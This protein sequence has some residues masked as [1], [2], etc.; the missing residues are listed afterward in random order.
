[1]SAYDGAPGRAAVIF[2]CGRNA[3]RSPMAEAL[4]R[5]RFGGARPAVSCGVEPAAW[6]DGFMIAV[7]AEDGVDMEAFECRGLEAVKGLAPALVV[8]MA[9]EADAPAKRLAQTSGARFEA[10]PLSDPALERGGRESKL[11]AYRAVR[12]EIA[13]RIARCA[14]ESG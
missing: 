1:M 4:W 9:P 13:A 8:S 7:M 12:D 3:V 6:P 11:A 5:R 14:A 10:W 2:V